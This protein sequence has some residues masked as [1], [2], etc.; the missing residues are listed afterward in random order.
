MQ[1][2]TLLAPME[3][4]FARISNKKKRERHIIIIMHGHQ[5]V[6]P[7]QLAAV[8]APCLTAATLS[9]HSGREALRFPQ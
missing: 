1:D 6:S 3:C 4:C 2:V 9:E 5:G 7:L 8:S